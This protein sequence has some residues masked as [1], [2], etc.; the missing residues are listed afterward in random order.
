MDIDRLQTEL[1][2]AA[3]ADRPS[4]RVPLAFERRVMARLAERIRRDPWS[5]WTT[6]FWRAAMSGGAIALLAV[7]VNWATPGAV[8]DL[9]ED[10]ELFAVADSA[11]AAATDEPAQDLW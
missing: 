4:D 1:L 2:R 7:A 8:N 5:E 11:P 10:P 9:A 3:R 6:A